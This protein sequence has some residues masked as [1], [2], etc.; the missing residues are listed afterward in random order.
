MAL[1]SQNWTRSP[2][3]KE[4]WRL[5]RTQ[6]TPNSQHKGDF[7]IPERTSREPTLDL[8]RTTTGGSAGVGFKE[9][10]CF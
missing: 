5:H 1:K 2:I 7:V 10:K 6:Q 9:K 4:S 3:V 8:A